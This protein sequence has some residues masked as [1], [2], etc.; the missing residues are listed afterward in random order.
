[1]KAVTAMMLRSVVPMVMLWNPDGVMI[2]NDAYAVFAGLRHPEL[3]GSRVREGW[4]EVAAFNDNVM[5]RGLAGENLS[6]RD[7]ELIL[8]RQGRAEQVWMN[9]DYSPLLD[10]GGE[11]VGVMA[12]VVETTVK[13]MAERRLQQEN[14]RL[15]RLFEQAPSFMTLLSGPSHRIEL[16][17]PA[18]LQ[19]VGHRPLVG[20]PIAQA[21]PDAAAQGYV[22]LLD[23]V[24]RSGEAYAARGAKYAMQMQAGGAV[25]DRYVDF[26]FQPIRNADDAVTGIFV[27]GVDVTDRMAAEAARGASDARLA[28]VIEG[29]K[30]YAILTADAQGRVADWSA[31]AEA[32]F[33][34]KA[35]EV[36]GQPAGMLFTPEDRA[37]GVDVEELRIA[38]RD[39]CADDERWHLRKDGSRVFMRG[40]V[41]PLPP[42][43]DGLPG[44][45]LR[46]A[47]D[48]TAREVARALRDALAELPERLRDLE[49]PQDITYA[50][51]RLLGET[52]RVS[53]VGFGTIDT[54]TDTLHV[55]RDWTAPDV[56]S[57]AGTTPLRHYGSFIE[58]LK[59]NEFVSIQDV[60]LDDRT[61]QAAEAL[62]GRSAR[63]FVNVPVVEGGQLV[64]V[65]YVND[66]FVRQWSMEELAFVREIAERTR[67]AAERAHGLAA[68][69]ASEARL[70]DSNESLEAKVR[71]RTQDL[72]AAEAA[73]RQSQKMEAIGQLTGGIAHDFNN[74][75]GA[76]ST[77]LQVLERRLGTGKT[78]NAAHYIGMAQDALRRA[79]GLTH[80]LLAFSRRQTL[81]PKAI[82]ANRLVA[83]MEDL[84]RR[85]MGP[86]VDVEVVGAGGLWATKIDAAQLESA[87]LNLCINARDAMAPQGGRLTIETANKWLDAREAALRDVLPGQYISICVTDTGTGMSAAT[88]ARAFDPFYTTKPMGQGT[89]L[90]LSMVYGFVRQ[91]G[92]QV[93]VYSEIGR[94]TTMCLYLP[95]HKGAAEEDPVEATNDALM[96]GEGET[97]L[98]IEDEATIRLLVVEELTEAGYRVLSAQDAPSG[99]RLLQSD[100]RIDLLLTDVGLPGG[101]NGRQVA[102][103]GRVS[104]PGLKVL[105]ITGYAENATVGNG[106]LDHGMQ[107]ITKPFDIAALARRVRVMIET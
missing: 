19:L 59:R 49:T 36:V 84:I 89:G 102:D 29:A 44:G 40:I 48:E 18:Y 28:L 8:H 68:L 15:A 91:S 13:V 101:L 39:G 41:R 6:Y 73:L 4:N 77:S 83:G 35:A 22:E 98:V 99:L 50:A 97:I 9:L 105:F 16:A 81:D 31:G 86:S 71:E 82:D 37:Q 51:V 47:R 64:A 100:A 79:A 7:Q 95:R 106:L 21:L 92:G 90:G 87:L 33:G 67:L 72:M 38:A 27:E 75:L 57:L 17:N 63:S 42:R 74:L 26:V 2:Y 80:R 30:D 104:R 78:D 103:A 85:T 65:L 11:P 54:H 14:E 76:M 60:R 24:Y 53:R 20:L 61:S 107:V 93:R 55:E 94:G 3:L 69:R 43:P 23:N 32:I 45:F 66:A 34:W 58:S 25:Q 46:I 88:I 96:Q 70:R 52:L 62:E 56:E 5:R 10:D 12:I 1:M